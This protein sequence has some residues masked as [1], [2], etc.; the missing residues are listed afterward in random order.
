MD[1]PGTAE[2]LSR[3]PRADATP[4]H[5][6]ILSIFT[7]HNVD[8]HAG[9]RGAQD[10]GAQPAVLRASYGETLQRSMLKSRAL[11]MLFR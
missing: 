6:V 9:S 1:H 11:S 8:A 2:L 4:M 10:G 7:V 3:Q 5:L